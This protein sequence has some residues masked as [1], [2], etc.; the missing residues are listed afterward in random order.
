MLLKTTYRSPRR[1]VLVQVQLEQQEQR[2][3]YVTIGRKAPD[4]PDQ[5]L[6]TTVD[7]AEELV[8]KA[9]K[10]LPYVIHFTGFGVLARIAE[11]APNYRDS[12]LVTGSE[13]DFYFGSFELKSTV[14]VSFIRRS[15]TEAFI[16]QLTAAKVFIWGIHTGPVPLVALLAE[17]NKANVFLP[18]NPPPKGETM[19]LDYHVELVNGDIRKLE[20]NA[21]EPK[22]FATDGGFLDTDAAYVEAIR[23]LT[24]EPRENYHQGLDDHA[25]AAMRSNYREYVRFVKLGIGM[26]VFFLVTLIGNYFYVNHLN[27]EAAQLESDISGY[28]ENLALIDR[29]QQE[30]QRKLLLIDNS[31]VQSSK[32]LSFYL[33]DLA[34]SVPGA[35]QLTTLET[36][37]LAEPLKPKRKVELNTRRITITGWSGSSKVLDDWMEAIERKKWVAGVELINYVRINEQ[38]ATF[39]LLVK[40][41]E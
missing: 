13:E 21:G 28:G 23:R 33:D 17:Q 14:A 39:H 11:F 16:G 5:V 19:A 29:L 2:L 38:K 30:K 8:K 41:G 20:R 15:L 4:V 24:L 9:G 25:F 34:S 36:F 31:G 10:G 18:L 6:W 3:R 12:L 26:L 32:Y 40:I 7:S 35:I 27:G 37:P 1:L 22:R